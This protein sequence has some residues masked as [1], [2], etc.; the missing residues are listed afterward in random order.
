MRAYVENPALAAVIPMRKEALFGAYI[1]GE[2]LPQV[3]D[4]GPTVRCEQR[5]EFA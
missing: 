4:V 2:M 5:F 1:A 3:R